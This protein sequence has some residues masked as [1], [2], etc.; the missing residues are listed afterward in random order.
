M[1]NIEKI[2]AID[3]HT[4]AEVSCRQPHDD[5]RPEFDEA[6]A[7]FFK[8]THRPTIQETCDYY[9]SINMAL[10]MFTIDAEYEL[11]RKRIPNEE[12]AEAA[13]NNPDVLIPFASIL[14]KSVQLSYSASRGR[15]LRCRVDE[16]QSKRNNC[17]SEA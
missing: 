11:G 7:K 17:F 16:D 13:S 5:Y 4:H 12:I 2:T 8:S 14:Y 6:F 1:I 10:V 3:V 15:E 9:R